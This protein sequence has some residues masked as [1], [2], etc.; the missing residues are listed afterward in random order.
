MNGKTMATALLL[1]TASGASSF[2][3]A[4]NTIWNDTW[5]SVEMS[6]TV[7]ASKGINFLAADAGTLSTSDF[8]LNTGIN[9]CYLHIIDKTVNLLE[10]KSF[11]KINGVWERDDIISLNVL[12]PTVIG[13]DWGTVY[14]SPA[15]LSYRDGDKWLGFEG[16][17]ILKAQ[18]INNLIMGVTT[19]S[20]NQGMFY[21]GNNASHLYGTTRNG[22]MNL[23]FVQT[24]YVPFNAQV[25]QQ[26][27][28]G[29][30]VGHC[31]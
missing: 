14:L 13:T 21:L 27:S 22:I 9:T 29:V 24:G 23:I 6:A 26:Q 7:S 4:Q 17:L 5:F 15:G 19:T 1:M 2:A 18:V 31:D 28:D 30:A 11:C 16:L 20:P 25:C 12:S 8:T 10:M 3:N